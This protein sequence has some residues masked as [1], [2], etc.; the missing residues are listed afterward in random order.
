VPPRFQLLLGWLAVALS[1]FAGSSW[2]FWGGSEN[3]HEGWYYHSLLMNLG[4]MIAQYLSGMLAIVAAGLIAIRWPRLGGAVHA[5]AAVTAVRLLRGAGWSVIYGSVGEADRDDA[6]NADRS[7]DAPAL[8]D[9]LE[10][11]ILPTFANNRD[12][13]IDVMRHAIALNGSFFNT[14]RMAQQ[15]VVKAYFC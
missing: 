7:D 14:Q 4:L 6:G 12:C 9:K 15:Y 3:F 1:A 5:A 2:A 8:Y 13:F 10:R 11:V